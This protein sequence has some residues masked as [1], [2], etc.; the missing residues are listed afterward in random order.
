[1]RLRPDRKP[2]L[3]GG[4]RSLTKKGDE[5]KEKLRKE[6][7]GCE[8]PALAKEGGETGLRKGSRKPVN[9]SLGELSRKGKGAWGAASKKWA[10]GQSEKKDDISHRPSF[11]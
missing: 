1:M 7:R 6:K 11:F 8:M 2:N 5:G 10:R 9:R 3:G 4:G